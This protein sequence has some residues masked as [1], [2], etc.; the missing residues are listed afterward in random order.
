M[1]DLQTSI[2]WINWLHVQLLPLRAF[3][4]RLVPQRKGDQNSYGM[5]QLFGALFTVE[6]PIKSELYQ[7]EP[8]CSV[9][10]G[11]L[12]TI[13]VWLLSSKVRS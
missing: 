8:Y 9:K 13:L 2:P 11:V 1:T 7:A 10:N 4:D 3:W 6:T 5:V 12:D